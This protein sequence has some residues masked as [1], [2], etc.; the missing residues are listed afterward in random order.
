MST[1]ADE[2]LALAAELI[3]PWE[4]MHRMGKDGL[5]YPYICPAGIPTIGEGSTYY[6][7][8]RKVTMNDPPLTVDQCKRLFQLTLRTYLVAALEAS[9]ILAKYPRPWAAITSFNQNVGPARYRSST[10][11]RRVN[12][13]DWDGAREEIVKWN[14]GGG[15]VLRGLDLRR[16]AEARYFP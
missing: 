2:A 1:N 7:D 6:Y 5:V 14:R 4:G 3:A 11:R 12:A 9:P 15:R 10:L 16:R 13:E 8:G